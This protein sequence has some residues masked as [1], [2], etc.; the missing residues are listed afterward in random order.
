MT[1]YVGTCASR[2]MRILDVLN[3][4]LGDFGLAF[5]EVLHYKSFGVLIFFRS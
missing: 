5:E 1:N 4:H 2:Y 3:I